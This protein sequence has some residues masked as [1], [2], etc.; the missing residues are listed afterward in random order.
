LIRAPD[1]PVI[2]VR[3]RRGFTLIEVLV[4]VA[5]IALL[6]AI[7]LPSLA[8]AKELS[9]RTICLHNTKMLGQCWQIYH[10]ENKGEFLSG[11]AAANPN[12]G[13]TAADE[14]YPNWLS[15]NPP[16]WVRFIT[17][18]PTSKPVD[19]QIKALQMGALYKYAHFVDIYHCPS[20]QKNE[21]RTYSTNWGISGFK[22]GTAYDIWYGRASWK[23]D[24]LKP[25]GGRMVFIDDYP[26]D[27][28]A[29]WTV[30]PWYF[31]FWNNL[32]ARHDLG[33][34]M[35]FGDGHSEYW[36]WLDQ[37]T[38]K[39]AQQPWGTAAPPINPNNR[40][41][42]RLQLASWGRIDNGGPP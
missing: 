26:D 36:H 4:V 31:Q 34:T 18:S 40:D 2:D 22:P 20:T 11:V 28:D 8:R 7:L 41:I 3:R 38:I 35:G 6:I 10:T 25:P 17:T 42:R 32:A 33:N 12:D 13:T 29:V 27:W 15:S 21:I 30:T 37:E 9:R 19:I 5:I 24:Q 39:W 23:I 14:T 16:S 1:Q